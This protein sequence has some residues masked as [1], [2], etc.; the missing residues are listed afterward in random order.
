[1]TSRDRRRGRP[2]AAATLF[3][4][5]LLVLSGCSNGDEPEVPVVPTSGEPT[6]GDG[7]DAAGEPSAS[8]GS[9]T[10]VPELCSDL[11]SA[12]E[13]AQILQ[14]PMQGET[15]RVY[16]DEFLPDS[17]RTG[18]LTCSYGVPEVP[19]GTTPPPTPPPVPLE[20]AVSGY[21]EADIAAGRIDST[22][23]GAQ[24]AGTVVTAQTVAGRDGFL[25]TDVEDV[26][27]VMADDIR[28]YV[29]TLLHGV[30]PAAAEPVVLVNLAA[31][32]LGA[33]ATGT[34]TPTGSATAPTGSATAPTPS[35]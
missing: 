16:N 15:V 13:I 8:P 19:E 28:T 26:S 23:D 32:L 25:L 30:V 5:L 6:D 35:P 34:P 31:H 20:I 21:T 33:S 3:L 17:G 24:A 9:T 29:I 4:P 14:V 22:V 18:R 27:F 10:G 7:T 11:A 2:A 12:G 1:M